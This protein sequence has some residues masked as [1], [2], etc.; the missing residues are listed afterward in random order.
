MN[1][2]ANRRGLQTTAQAR[3]ARYTAAERQGIQTALRRAAGG[4]TDKLVNA[5]FS[6]QLSARIV[7]KGKSLSQIELQRFRLLQSGLSQSRAER[8]NSAYRKY[9][10]NIERALNLDNGRGSGAFINGRYQQARKVPIS[11]DVYMGKTNNALRFAAG[12]QG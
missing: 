11:R 5:I 4:G 12:G 2:A 6:Y 7:R 3:H 10:S 1:V 9:R 8:V